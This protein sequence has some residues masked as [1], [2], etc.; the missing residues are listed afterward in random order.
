LGHLYACAG[1]MAGRRAA[2]AEGLG[3]PLR[4]R[5][6]RTVR[7]LDEMQAEHFARTF[8]LPALFSTKGG[9]VWALSHVD[10][11]RLFDLCCL[12]P[13]LRPLLDAEALGVLD[14]GEVWQAFRTASV[15]G[16]RLSLAV[17][18][19]GDDFSPVAPANRRRLEEWVSELGAKQR[20]ALLD[21]LP[22][23]VERFVA[24]WAAP[25]WT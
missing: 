6:L 25:V 13:G 10:A 16:K 21:K 22:H 3:E 7:G 24:H 11:A 15:E 17:S 14:E 1:L 12:Y 18:E 8:E 23:Q 9:L 4:N 19:P 5:M 2:A 20:A